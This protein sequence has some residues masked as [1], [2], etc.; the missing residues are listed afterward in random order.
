M[1]SISEYTNLHY[2]YLSFSVGAISLSKLTF[3]IFNLKSGSKKRLFKKKFVPEVR[4]QNSLVYV[5][6]FTLKNSNN[7]II[8]LGIK[9]GIKY[10][11][12]WNIYIIN[13]WNEY[14]SNFMNK[15]FVKSVLLHIKRGI[16]IWNNFTCTSHSKG[17]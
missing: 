14:S 4:F 9:V 17:S 11:S 6:Q 7:F 12:V 1:H 5:F 13:T 10:P 15:R 3:Y 2:I 8:N 16:M